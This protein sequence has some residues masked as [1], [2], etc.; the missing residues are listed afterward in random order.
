MFIAK[1]KFKRKKGIVIFY[2][3]LE[4]YKKEGKYKIRNLKYLGT[5]ENILRVFTEKKD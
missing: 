1:K 5:A 4:H 3:V 2:Y